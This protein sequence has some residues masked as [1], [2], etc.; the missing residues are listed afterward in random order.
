MSDAVR[1]DVN[2]NTFGD[3]NT[4]SSRL[5]AWMLA[6]ELATRGHRVT[7]NGA[8][9]ASIEV[10]QKVRNRSRI[11]AALEQGAHV[12]FD[13]D[14]N[15]FLEG[16]GA[17]DEVVATMNLASEVTVGSY[18]L[19]ISAEQFH[20]RVRLF[21]N[22]LDV[23]PGTSPRP[24]RTWQG[25]IGW[26][27]NRTNLAALDDTDL[28]QHHNVVTVTRGG[29]IEWRLDTIDDTLKGFDL[30]VLP[31][32][33][34]EWGL[35]KNANRLLKCVALG[36]P[37]L[38]AETPE[39][40]RVAGLLGLPDWLLVGRDASWSERVERSRHS[41]AE[42]AD[43]LAA[44]RDVAWETFGIAPTATRWIAH[45]AERASASRAPAPRTS[46][47]LAQVDVIVLS[48]G[49]PDALPGTLRSLRLDEQHYASVQVVS[50]VPVRDEP[51]LAS[52]NEIRDEHDDFFEVYRALEE[53]FQRATGTHLLMVRAGAEL[54]PAFFALAQE[55]CL[56]ETITDFRLQ[57]VRGNERA[58]DIPETLSELLTRPYVPWLILL[59]RGAVRAVGGLTSRHA[60]YALWELL[61]RLASSGTPRQVFRT[62]V[63][64]IAAAR[65]EQHL[66]RGYAAHI[67]LNAP[68]LEHDLPGLDSEWHRL[69]F[70]LH[71]EIA[72]RHREL[73]AAHLGAILPRLNGVTDLP[74][75]VRA[76][77]VK[78]PALGWDAALWRAFDRHGTPRALRQVVRSTWS[79][80]RPLM[81]T[82]T[83]A[84]LYRRY[85]ALYEQFFPERRPRRR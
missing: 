1:L 60:A 23:P 70:T 69:R 79:L 42:L 51:T 84:R 76:T 4:G 39:H 37:A 73:F 68:G 44:A 64:T 28:R 17:R 46:D 47:V 12:V 66:M 7:V 30:V 45:T 21:E 49:D 34:S 22:P 26:F 65:L 81:P 6:D 53:S 9:L 57:A 20:D 19:K 85:R 52:A 75:M 25:R 27:G 38:I 71:S 14:D 35:S 24:Q 82:T 61:I 56:R 15:Y 16:V 11:E 5:R 80:I 3:R 50:A 10:F 58:D 77:A 48:D 67:A 18:K 83:R 59:P 32:S 55:A 33:D 74:G 29:T 43:A 2:F 63:A 36:V 40:A 41:Q 8:R 54:R 62:P 31:A 78:P 72:E 13:L